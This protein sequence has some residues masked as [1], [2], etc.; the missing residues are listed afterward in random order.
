M[1]IHVLMN[2]MVNLNLIVNKNFTGNEVAQI[3]MASK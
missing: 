1:F 2:T 3:S